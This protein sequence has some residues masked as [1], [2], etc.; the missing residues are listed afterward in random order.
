MPQDPAVIQRQIE[1]TRAELAE[2]VDA[3]AEIVSPRRV[4][5]RANE[6][7]R[8]KVGELRERIVPAGSSPRPAALPGG[9]AGHQ[10]AEGG[11]AAAGSSG[12]SGKGVPTEIVRT[13]RWER[14]ALASAVFLL[15]VGARRRRRRR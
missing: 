3:I 11:L 9:R 12:T 15:A 5:E 7:I 6:Q 8:V 4:A 13:V 1:Q 2:T 14:V 10:D